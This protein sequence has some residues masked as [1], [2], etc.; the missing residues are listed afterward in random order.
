LDAVRLT[1]ADD[2]TAVSA[3]QLRAV[4]ERLVT[5]GHW[6]HGD[7]DILIVTDAGYDVTR[8]AWL[9]ADLPVELLGRIRADRV[10]RGPAPPRVPDTTSRPP[11]HGPEFALAKPATWPEPQHTTT[12][13]TTRYGIATA[14]SWD[15][16]HAVAVHPGDE[17][18]RSAAVIGD[19]Q[20]DNGRLIEEP[21]VP[22][23]ARAGWSKSA[24]ACATFA[25]TRWSMRSGPGRPRELITSACPAE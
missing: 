9:L 25:R 22:A 5:A 8:L 2:A 18:G 17:A 15:R 3:D 6:T 16:P 7:P 24:L 21:A 13:A 12:T 20:T 14:C 4:V 23:S 19:E 11:R 1:P 10:L